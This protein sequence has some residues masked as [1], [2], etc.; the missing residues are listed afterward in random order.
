MSQGLQDMLG[1]VLISKADCC[2]E[3]VHV[4]GEA[5]AGEGKGFVRSTQSS[6]P[7]FIP[8]S[9]WSG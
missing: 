2:G 5:G 6:G 7:L 9:S 8:L 1:L 4:E 3:T